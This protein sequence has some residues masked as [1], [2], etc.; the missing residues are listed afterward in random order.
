MDKPSMRDIGLFEK[1]LYNHITQNIFRNLEFKWRLCFRNYYRDQISLSVL[2]RNTS[3][4]CDNERFYDYLM[5]LQIQIP[6]QFYGYVLLERVF[7]K[8]SKACVKNFKKLY[9]SEIAMIKS[10]MNKYHNKN[11]W[12]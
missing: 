8:A 7:S 2:I 9:P 11:L 12:I 4:L 5:G 6:D 3:T 10:L 1:N